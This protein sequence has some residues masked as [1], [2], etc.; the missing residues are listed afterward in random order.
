[1]FSTITFVWE[2]STDADG[3][4]ITY[5]LE[6]YNETNLISANLIHSNTSITSG[7]V[8]TSINIKLSDY[9]TKD[10]DYY[11]RVR[12]NDSINVSNWSEVRHFQYANW[13]ITFNLTDGDTGQQI[14]TSGSNPNIDSIS[15][16]N[17]F[18]VSN[19]ENP[20]TAN[21]FGNGIVECIFI[22]GELAIL[23]KIK[24]L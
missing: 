19:Q 1:M 2:N 24:Q 23:L 21:N 6:I 20:Y 10:D 3:D 13:T 7:S 4:T 9:T 18:D 12:A 5:D 15:C 8:N 17:G 16:N 11:W 14:S 22:M